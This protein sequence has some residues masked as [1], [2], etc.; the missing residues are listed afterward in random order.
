M[1]PEVADV[2]RI[3][4]SAYGLGKEIL[5]EVKKKADVAL[6]ERLNRLLF[7]IGDLNIDIMKLQALI[8]E[9]QKQL[10]ELKQENAELKSEIEAIRAW[11]EEKNQY[12]LA[13]IV[14]GVFAYRSKKTP[15]TV[16]L[17]PYCFEERFKSILQLTRDENGRYHFRCFKCSFKTWAPPPGSLRARSGSRER[18]F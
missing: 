14:P 4:K 15:Q 1:L 9:M 13:A 6:L 17:C 10:A 11:N 3:I 12:E 16:W 5:E 8:N 7:F 18:G 2:A